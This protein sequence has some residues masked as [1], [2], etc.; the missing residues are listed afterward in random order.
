MAVQ[1]QKNTE[2]SLAQFEQALRRRAQQGDAVACYQIVV[3]FEQKGSAA[4]QLEAQNRIQLLMQASNK[5]V[6]AAS[7]L[8]GRWYLNGHYVNKNPAQ[9]ILM[10]EH[11]ANVCKDSYGFYQLAEM[12]Q[13]G[14]GVSAD[15]EKGLVYLKK[16]V[17]MRNPD[18]IFTYANQLLST[19]IEQAFT[20]LKDNYKK[21]QHA[22]SLFF[23]HEN[24]NF[25]AEKVEQFFITLAK[26][27][28]LASALLA[29][30]CIAEQKLAQALPYAD[31]A[32]TAQHP[33]GFYVR[34]LLEFE[35]PDGDIEQ[36]HQWM[37]QAA[38]RGHIEAAYRVGLTLLTQAEQ[39]T[40]PS[41]KET[42]LQQALQFVAQAAHAG[43]APAQFTLGQCWLQGVG[44]EKK[45]QEALGWLERAAQQGH[46]DAM[47]VLGINLPIEHAQ[48]LPLLQAAAHAGHPKAML[49]VG[50]YLQ[51]HAQASEALE[52]FE[53]AKAHGDMR[54]NYMLGLAYLQGNG[55]AAESKKAVE[56]LNLAGEAG[57][58]EAYFAL[59]EAYRDGQG[60]RKNKK[61]QAKYLKLAQE[62]GLPQALAIEDS[63]I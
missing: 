35:R 14:I 59:Y 48:H 25:D 41:E 18:A 13:R 52:W 55:V 44:V 54:A 20:L 36:G 49:C 12:F 38:Q 17:A 1:E 46:V 26:N 45:Q 9:A 3:H 37:L 22:K 62:A 2:Q 28:A 61:S 10:F 43:F 39:Q 19:D 42:L 63:T 47:F 34:A 58:A 32:A 4:N 50:I 51:N 27:D 21:H 15:E 57:D 23:L 33:I 40:N 60:V 8:L 31:F 5:G 30:R 11:A 29:A 6:G 7:L 24:D 56:L 53:L 16:A